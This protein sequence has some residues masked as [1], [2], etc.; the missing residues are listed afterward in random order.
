[1]GEIV[2]VLRL[3]EYVGERSA[4]EEQVARSLHGSKYGVGDGIGACRITAQTIGEFP[5]ILG[6]EESK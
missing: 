3:I 2:R 4:V 6:K 1:M 5:D